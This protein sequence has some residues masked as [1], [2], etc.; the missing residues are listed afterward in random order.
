MPG[1]ET[2]A[3][4]TGG[5]AGALVG[6]FFVAVSIHAQEIMRSVDVRIRAGQTVVIFGVVMLSAVLL[7][8]PSQSPRALGAELLALGVVFG[9]LLELL[10]RRAKSVT[11]IP[12]GRLL[13][14]VNANVVVAGGLV[15]TGAL[16][17][18]EIDW[19]LLVVVPTTC[20]ALTSGLTSA[21][22]LLTRL[23]G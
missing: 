19:A 20:F 2:F 8:V 23:S 14:R 5:V 7:T 15:A 12:L 6:L 4:V 10:E 3:V 17:L 11:A 21:W 9:G 13:E 18:A 22:F 1:W 16:L